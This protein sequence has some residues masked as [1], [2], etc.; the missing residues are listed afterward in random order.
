MARWD[1]SA[2][3]AGDQFGFW[4]EVICQAFVPLTPRAGEARGD[5]P[6]T[7]ETR[8]MARVNRAH[9]TSQAQTTRHGPAEV[10]ATGDAYYFVN[11]QLA[12]RCRIRHGAADTVAAAGQFVVLDTTRPY[13][14]DFD[15]DWRML[16]FR[17]PHRELDE[18]LLGYRAGFGRPIDGTGTGAAVTALMEVLWAAGDIG[19]ARATGEL[20]EA[21]AAA[22]TAALT[23]T[24]LEAEPAAGGATRSMVLHHVRDRLAD[25]G[26]SAA[27][28]CAAFAISPRTLHKIFAGSGET[29]AATVRRLRLERAAALLADPGCRL[30]VTAVGAAVG[31][32]DPSSFA[33]A[34]R[35]HH[36]AGPREFR[37]G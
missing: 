7:V 10:A 27:S 21:F 9:I 36:G 33:R 13:Y 2:L 30:P 37:A 22:V 34:F 20:E 12:G 23:Q 24:P 1:T 18:R 8:P 16:S 29:F 14:L 6:S 32:P 28:V 3:P 35:R 4:H 5:F 26:L 25:S 17:V 31:F 19:S 15:R 11:L